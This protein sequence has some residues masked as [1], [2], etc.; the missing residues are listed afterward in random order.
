MDFLANYW[1]K[2]CHQIDDIIDGERTGPEA[3]LETFALAA[4][5]YSHPFYLRNI[6]A[7]KQI[8]LNVTSTY[9]DTVAWEN[10][11]DWHGAWSD[12]NRHCSLEVVMAS[13][14]I[15]GGY[16]H[17]RQLMPELRTMAFVEHHDKQNNAV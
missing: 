4:G 5:L 7:L 11:N 8:I 16:T 1:A 15:C 3:I 17:A 6:A 14:M 13:A 2:Y 10:E 9:A 12:H